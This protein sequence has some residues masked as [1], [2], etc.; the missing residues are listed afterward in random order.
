MASPVQ[1]AGFER[2]RASGIFQTAFYLFWRTQM[3]DMFLSILPV[4]QIL[5]KS[6]V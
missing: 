6:T 5:T 1:I 2:R 3:V 4:K